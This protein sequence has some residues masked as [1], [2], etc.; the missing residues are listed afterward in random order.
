MRAK[1]YEL[2]P[3]MRD[4]DKFN[5]PSR[6]RYVP[7]LMYFN[8][9]S[10]VSQSINTDQSGFRISTGPDGCRASAGES[11]PPGP[12]RLL[13]GGSTALG[14]GSTSDSTTLPSLLWTRHA[15]SQPWLNFAAWSFNPV[16]ELLLFTLYRH[17]LDEISDIV[18]MSGLNAALLARLPAWQQG[19]HGAFFFCGEYFQ[20]MEELR[21]MH[22]KT[23]W[24]VLRR[25]ARSSSRTVS[26][27]HDLRRDPATVLA[28]AAET[29]IR[30]CALWR[31]IA[32][33]STRISFAL[34]PIAPWMR[35][36]P[37]P[38]ERQLFD[39]YDE[40][41]YPDQGGWEAAHREIITPEFGRDF[42]AALQA[43][44]EREGVRFVNL[45]PIVHEMSSPGDWIFVDRAHFTDVGSDLVAKSLA[46][47]LELF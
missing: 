40:D 13:V 1:R 21:A 27:V 42:A 4:Y 17:V 10:F 29:T 5:D 34:Q 23:Y 36:T 20:K 26:T 6:R 25:P 43:G 15:P 2:T 7:Y 22:R 30:Q 38:E 3:H 28:A 45:N 37:C 31:R 14:L 35:H 11:T 33:P 39:E 44:C 46:K 12:L 32:G 19:N 16:Q 9:A 24:R 18:I 41:R 8:Q 47:E